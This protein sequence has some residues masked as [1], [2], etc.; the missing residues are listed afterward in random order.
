MKHEK[1]HIRAVKRAFSVFNDSDE[2]LHH[3][4][5]IECQTFVTDYERGQDAKDH[6][7]LASIYFALSVCMLIV[8]LVGYIFTDNIQGQLFAYVI[9][10]HLMI[11]S[12]GHNAKC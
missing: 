1:V 7:K 2:V 5:M 6:K 9:S 11:I 12:E 10:I 8:G 4:T 3:G